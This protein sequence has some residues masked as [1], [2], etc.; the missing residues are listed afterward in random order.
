MIVL[1]LIAEENIVYM[2]GVVYFIGICGDLMAS[3]LKR[4]LKIKDFGTILPGMGGMF[5]R[6]DSITI[7]LTASY[8]WFKFAGYHPGTVIRCIQH[9]FYFTDDVCP[10]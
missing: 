6:M 9:Y 3:C 2:V 8:Y 4:Q 7:V 10:I 1:C 5:D